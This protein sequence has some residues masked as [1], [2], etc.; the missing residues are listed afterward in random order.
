MFALTHSDK[1]KGENKLVGKIADH[2]GWKPFY[3]TNIV[4]DVDYHLDKVKCKIMFY[5]GIIE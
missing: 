2:K 5:P 3:Y 1:S 4:E